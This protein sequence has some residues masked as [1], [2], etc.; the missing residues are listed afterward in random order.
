MGWHIILQPNKQFSIWSTI[1]DDFVH[2]DLIEEE[3]ISIYTNRFGNQYRHYLIQDLE[4]IKE[5]IKPYEHHMDY[6]ECCFRA[7]IVHGDS[8]EQL[9]HFLKAC[10]GKTIDGINDLLD[11]H[12]EDWLYNGEEELRMAILHYTLATLGIEKNTEMHG[13]IENVLKENNYI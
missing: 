5:G 7:L 8:K 3:A 9:N 13:N 1:V 10:V 11:T 12:Y 2:E 6:E 4:K